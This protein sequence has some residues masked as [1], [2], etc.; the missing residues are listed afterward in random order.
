MRDLGQSPALETCIWDGPCAR[1]GVRR[2]WRYRNLAVGRLETKDGAGPEL[3]TI[4]G[5]RD[6]GWGQG[7]ER[8]AAKD[9]HSRE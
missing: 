6:L 8:D 1:G 5:R 7:L 2:G 9:S 4:G 3:S